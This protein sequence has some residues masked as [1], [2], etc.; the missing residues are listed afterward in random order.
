VKITKLANLVI[1]ALAASITVYSQ[2]QDWCKLVPL[3]SNRTEVEKIIGKPEKYFETYGVY[4]TEIGRFYVWYSQG[5]CQ[6]N[7]EGLQYNIPAQKLT[8]IVFSPKISLPLESY[9]SN[10]ENFKKDRHP[11]MD[12]RYFYTSPDETIT[13][14]T[15]LPNNGKE[16]VYTI[17]LRPSK[18]KQYLLCQD[19][20]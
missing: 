8:R 1:L 7:V 11:G 12:S 6:K 16:F 17:E 19:M 15:V 13:Y 2:T 9:V 20:K 18:D 5:G 4:Q 3:E 14:E 10:K